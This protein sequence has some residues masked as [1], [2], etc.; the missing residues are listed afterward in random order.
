M[1][2]EITIRDGLTLNIHP[3]SREPFEHFITRSGSMVKEMDCFIHHARGKTRFLDVGALHG[4][5]SLVFCK[6]NPCAVAIAVEP[7]PVAFSKMLYNI[8]A[9]DA[10]FVEAIELALSDQIGV[11]TM[12]Y[13]WEHLVAAADNEP[14]PKTEMVSCVTGDSMARVKSFSPDIMKI[15]VEGHEL[16]VLHGMTE[17]LSKCKPV[18]FVELHPQR[19]A[20]EGDSLSKIGELLLFHGYTAQF[21]D[22]RLCDLSALSTLTDIERIVLT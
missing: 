17:I 2:T 9:N 1:A 4:I 13:K 15:D 21:V 11:L 19:I 10:R 5:F 3:D 12:R 8:H 22:G 6:L 7:S 16:K 18:I 20:L 14:F